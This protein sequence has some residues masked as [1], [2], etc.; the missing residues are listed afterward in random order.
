MSGEIKHTF[1]ILTTPPNELVEEVHDRMP[2]IL[3]RENEKKWLDKY[4][5]EKELQAMLQTYPAEL[6]LS[7]PV[8]PLVNS[9]QNDSPG[10]IRRTSPMDQFGNYTLFG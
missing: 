5:G 8:S 4:T 7:Y 2:V 10:I 9:V 6:M 1:L 3:T